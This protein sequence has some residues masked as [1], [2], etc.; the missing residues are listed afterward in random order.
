MPTV[1][2]VSSESTTSQCVTILSFH[3]LQYSQST[4]KISSALS[5][6]PAASAAAVIIVHTLI[7]GLWKRGLGLV[8]A[9][10][11]KREKKIAA[12]KKFK[13]IE[14]VCSSKTHASLAS[15]VRRRKDAK[16]SGGWI[17]LQ[18]PEESTSHFGERGERLEWGAC[19]A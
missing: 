8:T 17:L 18:L 6:L 4:S 5:L 15:A 7:S 2:I 19:L 14:M 10:H 9:T 16:F 12:G 13:E 1:G 11:T 3:C